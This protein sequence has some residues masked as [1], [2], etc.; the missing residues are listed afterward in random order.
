MIKWYLTF[1]LFTNDGDIKDISPHQYFDSKGD[2]LSYAVQLTI[3]ESPN[4]FNFKC[5]KK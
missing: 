3:K 5:Y 2:C 4:G 1:I